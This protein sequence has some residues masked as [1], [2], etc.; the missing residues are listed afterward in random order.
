MPSIKRILVPVDF[1]SSSRAALAQ[2]ANLARAVDASIEVLHVYEPSSYLGPDS[3]VLMPVNLAEKWELTR[4][5]IRC[6]LE[7]FLGS[8]HAKVPL[9]VEIGTASDV[10]VAIAKSGGFDA[11][12]MGAHGGAGLSRIVGTVTEAVMRRAHCPVLT[13][14]LPERVARETVPM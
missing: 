6:E 1:S 7:A 13:V 11:V 4:A 10:I 5:Q 3:L 8:E 14:H 12:V 2:A 9:H